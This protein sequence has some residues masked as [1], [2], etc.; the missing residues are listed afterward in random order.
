MELEQVSSG[1]RGSVSKL[2]MCPPNYGIVPY[3]NYH[4]V[5]YPISTYEIPTFYRYSVARVFHY[6]AGQSA[7]LG[8]LRLLRG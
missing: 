8:I 3:S 2:P 6:A 7:C 4:K 1:S 5:L